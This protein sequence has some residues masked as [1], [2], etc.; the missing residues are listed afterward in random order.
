MASL[1]V[2]EITGSGGSGVG[3]SVAATPHRDQPRASR[4]DSAR[5]A[6]WDGATAASLGDGD[7]RGGGSAGLF[8]DSGDEGRTGGSGDGGGGGTGTGARMVCGGAVPLSL[9]AVGGLYAVGIACYMALEGMGFLDAAYLTTGVIT[10]VG[11]VLVP[12]TPLGRA[13]TGLFNIASLGL[14][15]MLLTDVAEWRRSWARAWMQ[16]W[17]PVQRPGAAASKNALVWFEVAV[18][19]AAAVPALCAATL[20]FH[21]IE[22]W[23]LG[24]SLYFS[25]ITASGLGMGDVEPR[26]WPSRVVFIAYLWVTMGVTLGL[27][28]TLGHLALEWMATWSLPPSGLASWLSR[29]ATAAAAAVPAASG[30]GAVGSSSSGSG[31]LRRR[32]GSSDSAGNAEG[33]AGGRHGVGTS[34]SGGNGGVD[35]EIGIDAAGGITAPAGTAAGGGEMAGIARA[36]R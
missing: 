2:A 25:L 14:G 12:R 9:L 36:L 11:L 30:S 7:D 1:I 22:G 35:A 18:L 34:S 19:A 4:T 29:I 27:L 3:G 15:V 16:R 33:G 26:Q 5:G 20:V 10:T 13:F 31:G 21:V 6:R 28:G 32:G 17:A 24:E 23:P 8:A